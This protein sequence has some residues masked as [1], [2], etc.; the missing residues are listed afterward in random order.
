MRA[1]VGAGRPT[2]WGV[3]TSRSR[4]VAKGVDDAA[5]NLRSSMATQ[6][7]CA[8]MGKD[9]RRTPVLLLTGMAALAVSVTPGVSFAQ[10][11]TDTQV[12]K[13]SETFSGRFLCQDQRFQITGSGHS[14]THI[15]AATDEDGNPTVPLHFHFLVH[16]K[17]V[18]VPLDGTGPTFAGRFRTSDTE[19]IRNV[20]QGDVF[21]ET[22]TDQN[23]VMARGSDGSRVRLQEHHHFTMNANGEVTIEFDKVKASC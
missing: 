7:L 16:A 10:P 12:E 20:K 15:T 23:N 5:T 6:S 3:T 13:F 8:Q 18:A 1:S 2:T 9:V 17:V 11:I 22:D 14:V 4:G 19:S 21:V